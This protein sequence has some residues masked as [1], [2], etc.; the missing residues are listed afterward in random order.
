MFIPVNKQDMIERGW[1]ELDFI[2]ILGDAYVDH[3]SFGAAIITRVLE[4]FGYRIGIIPHPDI[5]NDD[6]FKVLGT[7]KIGFMISAGNIDTM[8]NMYTSNKRLRS[9]DLYQEGGKFG[10]RPKDA[11]ITYCKIVK[12]LFPNKPIVIGGIEASLRRLAHYDYIK[13]DLRKSIL[14]E[15]GADIIS[16]GMGD[17]GIVEI[18]DA[19]A[20]GIEAKDLIYLPG[21]TWKTTDKDLLPSDAIFLPTYKELRSDKLNYAKSFN[22]QYK[23]TDPFSGK[24][25]VEEYDGVYVV[26]NPANPPLEQSYLDWVY[27]L[28]YERRA[29]PMYK[30]GV[31]A[32]QEVKFSI[33]IN[34]GCFGGCSF[35]AL[36]NHQGRI[37]QSRSKESVLDEAHKLVKDPD[38]KGY[39]HDVGG[40][41]ANFYHKA[42]SKQETKGACTEKQCLFPNRCPNLFVSHDDYLDILRSLRSIDGVK[43][44]F[45]RSGIRYDYLMYDKKDEFFKELITHHVSGQLKVAPE[46]VSDRVLSYMQKPSSALYRKFVEKYYKLN[47]ELKKDQY[48]VPY[49]MSSHP[50]SKLEDAIMLA[51]YIRDEKIYIEQVQDFYPTPSTISTCMYYT[52]VDPRTMMPVFV[53]RSQ[54]DKAMQRA[55]LQYK[56]PKNYDLVKE[57]LIKCKRFDLIGNGKGCLIR[58][59]KPVNKK[60]NLSKSPKR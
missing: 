58:E 23:N 7:P 12:R 59:N 57:A 34:R 21:T 41:T 40:P 22:I 32:L 27:A 50:G 4:A 36:T 28:P 25:L 11:T 15:S 10:R 6:S 9:K 37:I 39:I 33:S 47:K 42:C 44:V 60:N 26:Q 2:Y 8:V 54:K 14:L 18:A 45:I 53:A 31:P 52:G 55:L 56:D 24:P 38:F 49:L 48:L 35:C 13:D 17:K 16:Y 43:K 46:H 29:H 1:E 3:P 19:L 20:S 5:K 30:E 51:E